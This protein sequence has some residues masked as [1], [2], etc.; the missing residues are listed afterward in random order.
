MGYVLGALEAANKACIGETVDLVYMV[1]ERHH[2]FGS[3]QPQLVPIF[4]T[5]YVEN[6]LA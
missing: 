6:E 5:F 1:C 4:G 2:D 3:C